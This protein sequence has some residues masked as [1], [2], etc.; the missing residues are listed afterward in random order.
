M[1]N[2]VYLLYPYRLNQEGIE[3]FL[4]TTLTFTA[5][6]LLFTIGVAITFGWSFAA[7]LLA[8]SLL[9]SA[10]NAPTV[11]V[12]GAWI[13]LSVLTVVAVQGLSRAFVRFDPSQDTPS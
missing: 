4:R 5:K 10:G 9:G 8:R 2:L 1:D 7:N 3:I 13:L 6:G 12:I 11:F